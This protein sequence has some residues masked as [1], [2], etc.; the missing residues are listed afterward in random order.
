M[1]L[2]LEDGHRGIVEFIK[3]VLHQLQAGGFPE[4]IVAG[5]ALRD[6]DNGQERSI[7]DIDVFVSDRSGY[8]AAL[9]DALP[10]FAYHLAVPVHVAQYMEFEGVVSVHEFKYRD[11]PPVQIVVMKINRSTEPE[12]IIARHDFG[13]CQIAFDGTKVYT[14]A[15]YQNDHRNHTFSIIR[16]RDDKDLARSLRRYDRLSKK[17]PGWD[18]RWGG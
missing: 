1:D 7:K 5:G 18:L 15:A 8:L 10:D 13:I 17:Y 14:T 11:F 16:C 9:I 12:D 2:I 4:A 6:L 3:S